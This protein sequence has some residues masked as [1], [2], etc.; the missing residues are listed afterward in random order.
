MT[1]STESN[2][3]SLR[4]LLADDIRAGGALD[5]RA[6]G[7]THDW[8]H[9]RRGDVL[10]AI[11]E[12]DSDGHDTASLAVERGAI[13]VVCE[14]WL[15]IFD[16]PQ[17]VVGDSRAA[18]GR[19]CQ[20]LVENPSRELKVIGVTGTSGKSTV[21]RLLA[22]I[23]REAGYQVGALDSF[24]LWDGW[25]EHP[26]NG[27]HAASAASGGNRA[28]RKTR[29][30]RSHLPMPAP[31]LARSLAQMVSG[32]VSH[33][34]VEFSSRDLSAGALA[35]VEL[36]A[37]C[38]TNVGRD[39]LKWHASLE[40][41]R[42]A[43]RHIFDY[44]NGDGIAIL[45]A[46]CPTSMEILCEVAQP[47]LTIGLKN[48]AEV[49]ADI[50]E[51][52]ANEQLFVMTAGDESVGVR[53]SMI[54]DHHIY[55]C[56]SA[57][58]TCLGYGIDLPTIARGLESVDRLPGRMELV[59]CG[60]EF[61]AF[62]D[63][64]NSPDTV[65]AALRAARRSTSGR[66]LVVYGASAE[67]EHSSR[68]VLGRVLGAMADVVVA[69]ADASD[70]RESCNSICSGMADTRRAEVIPNRVEAIRWALEEARAGDTVL[71]AGMGERGYGAV[72]CD[73]LQLCDRQV[74]EHILRGTF[75]RV[76][77]AAAAA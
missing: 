62:V 65:R 38:L 12:A 75:D 59:R 9:V 76:S 20:A 67:N 70:D 74:A 56:L 54:G 26:T 4:D 22:S 50:I 29:T 47:A 44:L 30:E 35:G 7:C 49:T 1:H 10:V 48:P 63:A 43:K 40:N 16:V 27:A 51:Q 28:D 39:H 60:Q 52:Y 37:V 58:A 34:M 64:A 55:N 68:P 11:C 2:G 36:D 25:E 18:Y 61:T 23:F 71:I 42:R 33:A 17:F 3:I 69:T 53:T 72:D 57:A 19:I 14:R 31:L 5:V 13:A 66:L 15:P 24:G 77:R 21:T 32:G 41:Y 46:D 45:N 73:G 6:T 8:R